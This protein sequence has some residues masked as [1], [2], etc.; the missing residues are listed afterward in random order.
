M[1]TLVKSVGMWVRV[2]SMEVEHGS[3]IFT[4]FKSKDSGIDR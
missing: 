1:L 3:C 4:Y 2:V